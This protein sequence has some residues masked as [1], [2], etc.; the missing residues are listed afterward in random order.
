MQNTTNTLVIHATAKKIYE[1]LTS[2]HAL[3]TWQ[4]P[5]KMTGK[6]HHFD[7]REG[8]GYSMSLYYPDDEPRFVGKTAANEDRFTV[9]FVKLLPNE[10]IIQTVKFD[11][12]DPDFMGEMTME[13]VLREKDDGTAVTFTYT[14]LPIGIAPEDNEAGTA[15]SLKK[16]A[17][18]VG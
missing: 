1:A 18:Y 4:A 7:L 9:R 17:D 13:I 15:S 10:K 16:L 12:T 11:T 5:H 6:V 8:G 2:A 14:G 3:E